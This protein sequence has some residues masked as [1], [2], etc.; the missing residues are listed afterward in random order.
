MQWHQ[1]L[2]FPDDIHLSREAEDLVC[3][4]VKGERWLDFVL[5]F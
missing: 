5:T 2:A 3:R 1:Y 4:F